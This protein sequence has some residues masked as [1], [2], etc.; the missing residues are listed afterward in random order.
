MTE[1]KENAIIPRQ[2][3]VPATVEEAPFCDYN[4][5]E[6]KEYAKK[7]VNA[8][9]NIAETV[10]METAI[11]KKEIDTY[12]HASKVCIDSKNAYIQRLIQDTK[13]KDITPEELADR[14]NRIE[15]AQKS[16]LEQANESIVNDINFFT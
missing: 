7:V 9:S 5:C 10:K 16:L 2:N 1:K 3:S 8:V 11:A 12:A 4:Y 6:R 13:R 15:E 14:F